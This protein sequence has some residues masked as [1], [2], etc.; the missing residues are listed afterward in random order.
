MVKPVVL[1]RYVADGK[2]IFTMEPEFE[3]IEFAI[4]K[5]DDDNGGDTPHFSEEYHLEGANESVRQILARLKEITSEVE[6]T[7]VFN[8]QKYYI[9]IKYRRNVA[10]LEIRKSKIRMVTMLPEKKIKTLVKSYSITAFS[11]SVQKF[12]G[13]PCAAINIVDAE[14]LN[15]IRSILG[16]LIADTDLEMTGRDDGESATL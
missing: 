11:P 10:Y 1:R 4:A 15:E 3:G 13:R 16:A 14:H 9:S 2:A 12:Y 5:P 8:P 6:P 7:A